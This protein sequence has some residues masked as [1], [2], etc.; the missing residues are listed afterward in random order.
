MCVCTS[1]VCEQSIENWLNK[2][3]NGKKYHKIKMILQQQQPRHFNNQPQKNKHMWKK[4]L[5]LIQWKKKNYNTKNFYNWFAGIVILLLFVV[6]VVCL[7]ATWIEWSSKRKC[8]IKKGGF[9]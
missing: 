4:L 2:N 9:V 7:V 5:N 3:R 1:R 8:E 6:V